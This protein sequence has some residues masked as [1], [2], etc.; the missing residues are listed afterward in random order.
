MNEFKI[1]GYEE[2]SEDDITQEGKLSKED[3]VNIVLY[4][5]F[6]KKDWKLIR[7]IK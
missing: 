6:N 4:H 5:L 7:R 3:V 2:I 1:I